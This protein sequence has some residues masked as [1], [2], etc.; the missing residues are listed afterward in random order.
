MIMLKV[1]LANYYAIVRQFRICDYVR[2]YI[3]YVLRQHVFQIHLFEP[4]LIAQVVCR[5]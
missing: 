4:C 3:M 1:K 2:I 5:G